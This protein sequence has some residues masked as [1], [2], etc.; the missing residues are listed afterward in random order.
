MA[1]IHDTVVR[2]LIE[3]V[4]DELGASAPYTWLATGSYGRRE[5]FPSSD[6]D[7]ALAWDG[8]NDDPELRD[9]LAEIALLVAEGLDAAGLGSD[10]QGA[11]AGKPLFTRSIEDWEQATRPGAAT[12][13]RGAA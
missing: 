4:H 5:P 12:P 1:G 9:R 3:I 13:T 8:A 7:S 10:P 11:V 2:R 6:V